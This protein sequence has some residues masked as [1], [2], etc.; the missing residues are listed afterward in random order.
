MLQIH[1][2]SKPQKVIQ[3]YYVN[4]NHYDS[5]LLPKLASVEDFI[6]KVSMIDDV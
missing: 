4:G 3:L 5:L 2:K 6:V 1:N